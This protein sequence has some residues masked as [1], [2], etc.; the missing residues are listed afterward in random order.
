MGS[1]HN[2]VM[3]A[4]V[5]RP[6]ACRCVREHKSERFFVA[7]R[8]CQNDGLEISPLKFNSLDPVARVA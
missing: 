2:S 4:A 7:I 6:P 8:D 5:N 1:L 3:V